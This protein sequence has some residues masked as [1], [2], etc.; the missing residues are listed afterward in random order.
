MNARQKAKKYK[1]ELERLKAQRINPT[2]VYAPTGFRVQEIR[3]QVLLDYE[4]FRLM[5]T[6][7]EE[8]DKLI[9]SRLAGQFGEHI[10]KCLTYTTKP[11]NEGVKIES[12]VLIGVLNGFLNKTFDFC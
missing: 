6:N 5:R 9:R 2:I 8:F 1:Q 3:A 11:I 12:T 4:M 10:K 7:P